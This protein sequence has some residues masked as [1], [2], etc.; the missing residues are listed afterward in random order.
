M[1]SKKQ[2]KTLNVGKKC[3]Y[4]V[5]EKPAFARTLCRYHYRVVHDEGGLS[6]EKKLKKDLEKKEAKEKK[7][8]QTLS[9][10]SDEELKTL[11]L[12]PC[13]TRQEL[14][15]FVK[16]FFGLHLPEVNVSRFT[17]TNP[18]DALWELY[19]LTV[20]NRNPENIKELVYCASRGSGKCV[21]KGTMLLTP[22]GLKPIEKI[23]VGDVVH[24]GW[25]WQ[26]TLATF[27]EG[28]KKS[29]AI[30][31]S[32]FAKFGSWNLTGSI[33]HRVQALDPKTGMIDWIYMADLVPGQI[34]Y[35]SGDT[36]LQVD[37]SSRDYK[38]GWLA[39]LI[40]GDGHVSRH[41]N[42]IGFCSTDSRVIDEYLRLSRE[43]F[44]DIV[45]RE[46]KDE[47]SK[48]LISFKTRDLNFR[49]WYKGLVDGDLSY[50]KKLKTLEHPPSF[51]AGFFAGM[52][53][54]DGS[55]ESIT[56]ANKDL[57]YQLGQILTVF[58]IPNAINNNRRPPRFSK[59]INE[60][61]TYHELCYKSG[62]H[63]YL[64]PLFSKRTAFSV[65]RAKI[66]DQFRY[67][68]VLIKPFA[69]YIKTKYKIGMGYWHI[70]GIKSR[71]HV[72]FSDTLWNST[73]ES[74]KDMFIQNHKIDAFIELADFLGEH[75]WRDY[76][77]FIRKGYFEQVASVKMGEAYF[78]DIE[79]ENDHSYWSNGFVSHNTL[80]VAIAQLLA[81][82][83][84]KRDVVHVGAILSQAERCYAYVKGFML[85]KYVKDILSPPGMGENLRIL[86]KDTMSKSILNFGSR[87]HTIEIVPCTLKAVNGPHVSFVTVDE[88]DTLATGEQMKAYKDISG[89]LDSRDGKKP[90]RVNISTRKSRYGLMNQ[91]MENAEKQGR[92]VRRWTVFEFLER[93]PES[94]SG[95]GKQSYLIDQMK[96]DVK[97]EE[98]FVAV[99]DQTKKE[100]SK[101]DMYVGCRKC[102]IAPI[103]LGDAKKQ[104]SKSPML[105]SI[106]EVGQKVLSEGPDWAL[107][108]LMNLKPSV[109]GIV[110]KEFDERL[111]I[112]SWNKMW[113]KLTSTTFPGTCDHDTF[114]KKC[115]AM[116]L[117][118]YAG[119]DWG[120]SNPSTLVVFFVDKKE[121]I[122]VVRCDGQ[123]YVSNPT[124]IN[125]IKTKWHN[126]YK[127]SLYFPDS[128]DPGNIQEMQKAGLPA[129]D[130]AGKS[131][132]ITGVQVV[133][134]WLRAPG[135]AESK[136]F[137]AEETCKPIIKEFQTYHFKTSPDGIVSDDIDTEDDH[138]LD[139]LRYAMEGI[140]GKASVI[141]SSE[142]MESMDTSSIVNAN[143]Q[144][145]R[146]PTPA[147]WAQVNNVAISSQD[148]TKIGKMGRWSELEGG[149]DDTGVEGE[150]GMMWSF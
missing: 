62:L 84:G 49:K 23:E 128:A 124:W 89:M 144:Y 141:L 92:T 130:K 112:S 115:H 65:F 96:F 36:K 21:E 68:A 142:S 134:K 66:N 33:N 57:I 67:P 77:S 30:E 116:G 48:F 19:E 35:K 69:E 45:F 110:Y 125:H 73:K 132:V 104:T 43:M 102:P 5:C 70:N 117:T 41:S 24:S 136:I 39:G 137:F 119:I 129:S 50:Y 90:L 127:I 28:V 148:D 80:S 9:S 17:D 122:Y 82:V 94:R 121:N 131:K 87:D 113:E 76:L 95:I 38:E 64:L 59:F 147:E 135:S 8:L 98:E 47:R 46:N 26:R 54:T 101:Y 61:V 56:L 143:G 107:S 6:E 60:Y 71:S 88:V 133:K 126:K 146:P 109:E 13:K 25:G 78:H 42:E 123:T 14:M 81:V 27:D 53:E 7:R 37:T 4:G 91:L 10:L 31:T 86:R 16:F 12:T 29:V 1:M 138:W 58:G 83:H 139:G 145:L 15:N 22:N 150:G 118:A 40:S 105:K 85:G 97:T 63:D 34:V 111:H 79:V 55:K 11:F 32:R 3:T 2:R 149:D 120:W 103:C 100:Y 51:L 75:K 44:P 74:A 108:Q 52:M 93:C 140:F 20:L 99:P 106:D 18:F 114:V 72:K